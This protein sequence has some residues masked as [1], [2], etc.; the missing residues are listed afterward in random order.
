[1]TIKTCSLV[2][3]IFLAAPL[4]SMDKK[5]KADEL[6]KMPLL[7]QT[8]IRL[9]SSN[10][11]LSLLDPARYGGLSYILLARLPKQQPAETTVSPTEIQHTERELSLRRKFTKYP[12]QLPRK[13]LMP[14]SPEH[15]KE[16]ED[17][18]KAIKEEAIV[19]AFFY[20][21]TILY[22]HFSKIFHTPDTHGNEEYCKIVRLIVDY[23]H[24]KE[25]QTRI[26]LTKSPGQA[27]PPS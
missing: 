8:A 3:L 17:P 22:F 11:D 5:H 18:I 15:E 10:G 1:M 16:P 24:W 12:L 19:A 21:K 25:Y 4:Y 20:G 27:L 2:Y 13:P 7:D 23:I 26:C 6:E 14:P 9:S